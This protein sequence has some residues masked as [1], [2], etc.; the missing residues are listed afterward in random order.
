MV[1]RAVNLHSQ[2]K[3]RLEELGFN[4]VT[5]TATAKDGL[6]M[7]INEVKPKLLLIGSAFY[8]AGTPFMTGR[9]HKRFPKLNITA[10]SVFDYPLGLAPWFIWHGGKSYL[11]LWEGYEEFHRGLQIVREGKQYISPLVQNLI[12]CRE[13]WPD[14]KTNITKREQECLY[15]MCCGFTFDEIGNELHLARK[16]ITNCVGR[17]YDTLHVDNREEAVALAW[18]LRLVTARDIRF[19]HRKAEID[20]LPEWAV[21]TRSIN[22][23]QLAMSNNK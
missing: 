9:L 6:N 17:L 13:E 10:V 22:R 1:S 23:Y 16:S 12:D 21:I 19:H 4:D 7:L 2:I 20:R 15:L 18:E 5:V 3:K 8:Q 14:A 11:N